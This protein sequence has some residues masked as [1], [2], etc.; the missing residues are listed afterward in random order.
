MTNQ[1]T[2]RVK[3]PNLG[4]RR[5]L[6][7]PMHGRGQLVRCLHCSTQLKVPDTVSK[8]VRWSNRQSA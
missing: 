6:A 7:V 1:G 2:F 5:L 8:G 4:C 3:C